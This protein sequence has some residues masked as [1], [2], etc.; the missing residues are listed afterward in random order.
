VDYDRRRAPPDARR[1]AETGD[2]VVP[3]PEDEDESAPLPNE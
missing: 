2:L 3:D 1:E